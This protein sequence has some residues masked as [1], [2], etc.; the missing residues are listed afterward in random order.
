[1]TFSDFVQILV[2]GLTN[3]AIYALVGL[4]YTIVFATGRVI[5]FA[6]GDLLM[7]GVIVTLVLDHSA[8]PLGAAIACGILAAGVLSVVTYFGA[9]WPVVRARRLGFGWLVSTLGASI[10]IQTVV[11]ITWG[12]TSQSFPALFSARSVLVFGVPIS[13]QQVLTFVAAIVVMIAYELVR[14][15]SI[16]GKIAAAVAFDPEMAAGVG[17]NR[18][19]VTAAAFAIAGMLAAGAGILVAPLAFA[20]AY[21]GIGFGI[22][23]FVAIMVG[24]LGSAPGAIIAGIF[25]GVSEAFASNQFGEGTSDWFP[26]VLLLV[27]LMIRPRGLFGRAGAVLS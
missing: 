12:S 19:L 13:L 20:N 2:S 10:V 18:D 3:G 5:N 8:I 1:M 17:I 4:G 22:K 26:F 27:V 9:V 25:L 16:V 14:R 23:G 15:R 7:V 11:A 6:H 24:G 21:M